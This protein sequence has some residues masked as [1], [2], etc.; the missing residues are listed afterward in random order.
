MGKKRINKNV[1]KI[2]YFDKVQELNT[3]EGNNLPHPLDW[4]GN[5]TTTDAIDPRL[6]ADLFKRVEIKGGRKRSLTQKQIQ[7]VKYRMQGYSKR[8]A[9]IKAGYSVTTATTQDPKTSKMITTFLEGVKGRFRDLGLD[10]A[11]VA[12]KMKEWMTAEKPLITKQGVI[13]TTPDYKIQIE[14]YDRY[15]DIVEPKT[16]DNRGKKKELVLTEWINDD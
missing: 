12:E 5:T 13:G 9:M 1:E 3:S 11:F 7:S 2:D 16:T 8:Q 10:E 4:K 15:K 14:G 6:E